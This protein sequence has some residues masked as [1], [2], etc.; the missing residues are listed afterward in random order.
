MHFSPLGSDLRLL[1]QKMGG[2]LCF[3]V[4]MMRPRIRCDS[5]RGVSDLYPGRLETRT[6][7]GF[8]HFHSDDYG[9]ALIGDVHEVL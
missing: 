5:K 1:L 2:I 3:A 8:P 6:Q 9:W 7:R 4:E